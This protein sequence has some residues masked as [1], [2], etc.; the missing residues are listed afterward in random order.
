ML[1]IMINY[2]N[3]INNMKT[4]IMKSIIVINYKFYIVI[5]M[6]SCK[7]ESIFI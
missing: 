5:S 1:V 4:F 6:M 7:D 2:Y 3:I